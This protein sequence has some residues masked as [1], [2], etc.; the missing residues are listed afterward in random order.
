M[1]IKSKALEFRDL[2]YMTAQMVY[3]VKTKLLLE[4]IQNLFKW[5]KV[6]MT[7][8][9]YACLKYKGQNVKK[10]FVFLFKGW[11]YIVV[12]NWKCVAH[13][14]GDQSDMLVSRDRGRFCQISLEA[15]S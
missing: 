3:K 7:W 9:K 11:I 8:G 10:I 4:S 13:K 1:F 2:D 14:M 15:S 12:R 6:N 5:E